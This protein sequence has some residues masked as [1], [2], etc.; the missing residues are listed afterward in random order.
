MPD[1]TG[2]NP[3]QV[4]EKALLNSWMSREAV[5]IV[6]FYQTRTYLPGCFRMEDELV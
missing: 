1:Y 4:P 5:S 3:V 6:L 2:Y